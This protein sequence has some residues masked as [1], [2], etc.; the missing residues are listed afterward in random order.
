MAGGRRGRSGPQPA[1]VA[2]TEV[3][4][5]IAA[6]TVEPRTREERIRQ[7]HEINPGQFHEATDVP[8]D[9]CPYCVDDVA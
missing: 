1:G 5:R 7:V 9:R 3:V 4:V 8:P 2:A 6:A